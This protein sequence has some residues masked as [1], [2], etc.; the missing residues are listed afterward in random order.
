[1]FEIIFFIQVINKKYQLTGM[2]EENIW[3]ARFR[4][5]F[6]QHDLICIQ[7]QS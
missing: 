6:R 1:M 4:N 7:V 2:F 3:S 5:A